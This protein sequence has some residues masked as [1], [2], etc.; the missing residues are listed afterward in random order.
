MEQWREKFYAKTDLTPDGCR[1][2]TGSANERGYGYFYP[3]MR[4]RFRAHRFAWMLERGPIPEDRIIDHLCRNR[5]C[6]N[7]E[8]LRLVT[9]RQ[10]VMEA[11]TSAARYAARTLCAY[12]HPLDGVQRH[13]RPNGTVKVVRRCLTCHRDRERGRKVP[14]RFARSSS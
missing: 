11:D 3:A 2:W 14:F 8:H 9:W 13:R 10:N 12:G 1:V 7:V 5:L 6:V 4:V